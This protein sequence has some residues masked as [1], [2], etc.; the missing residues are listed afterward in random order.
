MREQIAYLDSSAIVKRYVKEPGSSTVRKLYLKAFSGETVISFSIWNIG[1]VLGALDKA[2][3]IGR[4][5]GR[6]Y[7]LARKRFL[8]ET[9]R[10]AKLGQLLVIPLKT[11]ILKE[12][13]KLIEKYHIYEADAIQIA[14]AKHINATQ[15]LTGDRKLH[16]I[17]ENEKINSIYLP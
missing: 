7:M 6:E 1:E 11:K 15:F 16:E 4:L 5:G 12:S 9:R 10:L 8:L 3:N 17:A 2:K 14:T 13:W